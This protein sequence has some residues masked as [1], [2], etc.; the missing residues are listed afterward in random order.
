MLL[1][2]AFSAPLAAMGCCCWGRAPAPDPEPVPVEIRL[3]VR[4][5][6]ALYESRARISAHPESVAQAQQQWLAARP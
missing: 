1:P 2:L 4:V 6:A 3:P 5:Q